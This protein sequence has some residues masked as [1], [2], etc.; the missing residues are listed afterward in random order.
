MAKLTKLYGT[1][2]YFYSAEPW[3]QCLW[4][5]EEYLFVGGQPS[6][7]LAV[8]KINLD[9]TLT[10]KDQVLI[11]Q[12]VRALWGDERFIYA[13]VAD[14]VNNGMSIFKVEIGGT[15]TLKDTV[16]IDKFTYGYL[17]GIT[18]DE[19]FIYVTTEYDLT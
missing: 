14:E 5:D 18:G 3:N 11:G 15:L 2:P 1:E 13:G 7:G 10:Q 17:T 16:L 4:C 12:N 19:R 9:G 6:G 8:Y